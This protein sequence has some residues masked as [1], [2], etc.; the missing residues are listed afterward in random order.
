MENERVSFDDV[1]LDWAAAE[2]M[3]STWPTNWAGPGR[4]ELKRKL[5]NA[6]IGALSIVERSW[7]VE[8]MIQVAA[9]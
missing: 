8:A 4:E 7:L 2:L 3:S 5:Q 6:G 1:M 9:R